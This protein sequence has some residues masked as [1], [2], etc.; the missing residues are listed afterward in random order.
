MPS[1]LFPHFDSGIE[2]RPYYVQEGDEVCF[3]CRVDGHMGPDAYDVYM[4]VNDI[5]GTKRL[6]GIF[7]SENDRGQRYFQFWHKINTGDKTFTYRFITSDNETSKLFV[8]PVLHELMLFPQIKADEH[9][10]CLICE[11]DTQECRIE[12]IGGHF[13]RVFWGNYC[14]DSIEKKNNIFSQDYKGPYVISCDGRYAARI[15]APIRLMVDEEGSA[16]NLRL[17]LAFPGSVIYGLGEKFDSVNQMGKKPLNYVVEKFSEQGPVTY[18]PI[19]FLFTDD[20]VSFLQKTSYPSSFSFEDE[21][22][23]GWIDM[24]LFSCCPKGGVLFE[25]ELHTGTP[26]EMLNA[27]VKQTGKAVL[28]PKWAF[29]P[30]MSSNGWNTQRESLAQIDAMNKTGIPATVMVLEA[31]S[32]EETFYIWNDAQYTPRKG[33]EP[34]HYNDFTF[35]ADGKWPDPRQFCSTLAQNGVKLILWQIPVIKYEAGPHGRQLDLDWEF[36]EEN[37]L[38]LKNEDGTP[39]HITEMWFGNSLIPDYTNPKTC[40]W[41]HNCRRYLIEELGVAGFKTDGGEFLFDPDAY[42]SNGQRVAEAHNLFPNIYE[43]AYHDLLKDCGGITFSRAGFTGAQCYPIHWAGDQI[44]TFSELKGQLTAGLSLGL[45]G[46]P[47]WGFD[48]GGFAGDFPSTE[49]YLRS[50]ALAVF[51]PV[52]Q[53]HSEPRGGQYY[54]VE[55]NHW[56]NDRSPWNMAAAN[57]DDTIIP[58]YRMYANLRMNLLPYIW[59]AAQRSSETARPMMAH[60]IYDF[61][62][63]EAVRYIEDEY[64][65]GPDLLVAP[66][67]KKGSRSRHIYLPE[68]T[69]F[70]LWSGQLFE[71]KQIIEYFCPIDRIPVFAREGAA[72][73]VNMNQQLCM[74]TRTLD[75]IISN[76]IDHYEQLCFLLFGSKG[77]QCFR[78]E[79]GNNFTLA[80]DQEEERVSGARICPF[81]VFRLDGRDHGS[82]LGS[83]FGRSVR[84]TRKEL[85]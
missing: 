67:I 23:D 10:A 24:E 62:H 29:G 26:A 66:V 17:H 12:I 81:T 71:G 74:G 61:P 59:Q 76:D 70:D 18:L 42:F 68:G 75:G 43:A 9:E 65:F 79:Y 14:N 40:L 21:S 35:P 85:S 47:F 58:I 78:D 37:G 44:S 60:L 28:P 63:D 54:M 16:Y 83:I 73:P 20:G 77:R 49:L 52:M 41:W 8:C 31:W 3:G 33:A 15:E 1:G 84:G 57:Q 55:R 48:I 39:Y 69:W 4:E 32:D 82:V 64:M 50:V 30:W 7:Q 2:R 36:A 25:A 72:L 11:A 45:S 5:L 34:L 27:Y 6:K 38:C 13:I 53:F 46:V 19:P 51:A 80:W 56:N 22:K